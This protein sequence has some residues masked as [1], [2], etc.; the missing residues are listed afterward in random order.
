VTILKNRIEALKKLFANK[1]LDGY[2]V[3]D[4][5]NL[6]YLTGFDGGVRLLVAEDIESI[7]Y[8]QGV[9]Y[10]AAKEEAKD[11]KVELVKRGEDIN[12]KTA[13]EIE[14]L[15][16]KNVGFDTLDTS[17][18]LKLKKALNHIELQSHSDLI[19]ELRKVKDET[20]LNSIRKAAE[21]TSEGAKIASE[22]IKPGVREFEVAAEI[23]YAMRKLGSDGVAFDSIVVSGVRSAFP[24]GG[25]T[26][27]K[28]QKGDLVVV[29]IGAKYK[30]YR[31]DLTRTFVAG[32]PSAKQ[33]KI[34]EVVRN[35]Q[36]KA[37]ENL[38]AG[39]IGNK[40]DA[41]ARRIIEKE[42]YGE[43]FVHSLGHGVGLEVHESP[44]L[45]PESKDVLKSGNVVT[46]EP[47]I[48]IIGFGGF[49]VEDTVLV[50]KSKEEKL[51]KASYTLEAE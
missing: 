35:A 10:E 19:W 1:K 11:C 13:K 51:T 7:F 24:H 17:I 25:C 15:K 49:R 26:D 48:Y 39:A 34:Y 31:A 20:E 40:I 4:G 3:A 8:V 28:I 9:N 21:M 36:E 29:D 16:L 22:T 42:G 44:V 33:T 47:G 12:L 37:F 46:V 6:L 38:K 5:T 32:K 23:E 30:Y 43:Y 50:E 18:Y 41:V 2:M 27:K 45:S 14:R